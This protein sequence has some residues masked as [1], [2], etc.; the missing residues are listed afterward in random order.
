MEK[1]IRNQSPQGIATILENV[2]AGNK[3]KNLP[4]FV[5]VGRQYHK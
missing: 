4:I 3:L 1:R 2:I 5:L